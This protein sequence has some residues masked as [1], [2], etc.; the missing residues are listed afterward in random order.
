MSGRVMPIYAPRVLGWP[1]VPNTRVAPAKVARPP[2]RNGSRPASW[3]SAY[4]VATA[5]AAV[6]ATAIRTRRWECPPREREVKYR[7]AVARPVT[8]PARL[9]GDP[10]RL[11]AGW[12]DAIVEAAADA[13]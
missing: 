4:P 7:A 8:S 5:P 1:S 6:A 3:I 10:Y 9:L 13:R 2:Q 12:G 11:S